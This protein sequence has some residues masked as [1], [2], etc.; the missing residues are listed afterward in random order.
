[1]TRILLVALVLLVSVPVRAD[2]TLF[3]RDM[4]EEP[5]WTNMPMECMLTMYMELQFSCK[6]KDEG[7]SCWQKDRNHTTKV[8]YKFD[9]DTTDHRANYSVTV[10]QWRSVGQLWSSGST[11]YFTNGALCTWSNKQILLQAPPVW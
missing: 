3:V 10:G 2:N 1:M 5:H 6:Y 8:F 9:L 11:V 7:L 4:P